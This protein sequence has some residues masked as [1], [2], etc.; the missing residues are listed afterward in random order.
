VVAIIIVFENNNLIN[1]GGGEGEEGR[2]RQISIPPKKNT[3]NS[4]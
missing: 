4:L 3:L 2:E 1:L